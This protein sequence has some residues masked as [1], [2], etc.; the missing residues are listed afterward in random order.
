MKA[1]T[2]CGKCCTNKSFMNSLEVSGA[3]VLRWRRE[4][5]SDILDWVEVLGSEA[6]PW[7]DVWISP[8]TGLDA[9]RCP[10]VRK[11]PDGKYNCTIHD[12]RPQVC[13]DY[14][15]HVLHM[16]SIGCEMLEPDDNNQ[17]I[18]AAMRSHSV[19]SS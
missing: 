9:D 16:R 17:T 12:T 2:Q 10:F 3:D 7:G 1:C 6:D 18:A 5:R 15:V 13:R 4:Q 11:R 19:L 8:R 14:P